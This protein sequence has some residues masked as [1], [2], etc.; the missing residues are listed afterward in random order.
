MLMLIAAVFALGDALTTLALPSQQ[1]VAEVQSSP[2]SPALTPANTPG[3]SRTPTA[4]QNS[5]FSP[6][7]TALPPNF[8]GDAIEGYFDLP[9]KGEFET[10]AQYQERLAARGVHKAISA[11]RLH[12]PAA[13]YDA[14]RQVMTVSVSTPTVYEGY[15][16][17]VPARAFEVEEH[18]VRRRE[19]EAGNA[20][21]ARALVEQSSVVFYAVVAEA[22]KKLSFEELL[23]QNLD[24]ALSIPIAEARESKANV[25]VLLVCRARLYDDPTKPP[26]SL[27][28]LDDRSA[29]KPTGYSRDEPSVASPS[30]F[31]KYYYLLKGEVLGLWVYNAATGAVLGKFDYTGRPQVKK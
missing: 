6:A 23:A 9:Q 2:A 17:E 29:P 16:R 11:F 18:V 3:A 13:K 21:G 7:L 19:Y 14:D 26:R 12:Q 25:A 24:L 20:F 31:I 5:E 1:A 4:P 8:A 28:R 15:G 30:E 10:S 22:K 27:F